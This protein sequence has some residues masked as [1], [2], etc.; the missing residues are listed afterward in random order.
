MHFP[1]HTAVASHLLDM[2]LV[3]VEQEDPAIRLIPKEK[4]KRRFAD[5]VDMEGAKEEKGSKRGT[6]V[7]RNCRACPFAVLCTCLH[8]RYTCT[9]SFQIE[10]PILF[11]AS[12]S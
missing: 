9:S 12:P 6:V 2:R 3:Q 1:E 7:V 11:A 5:R 4:R 10:Q 8:S